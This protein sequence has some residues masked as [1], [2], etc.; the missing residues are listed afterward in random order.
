MLVVST[1]EF[2]LELPLEVSLAAELNERLRSAVSRV[3]R[4]EVAGRMCDAVLHI[5]L[6]LAEPDGRPPTAAQVK[7]ALDLA[8]KFGIDVPGY[9]L[10]DRAGMGAFLSVYSVMPRRTTSAKPRKKQRSKIDR[11]A[12]K[13]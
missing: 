11:Q 12:P 13:S 8:R 5:A 3:G 9:A 6:S 1:D 2:R 10:A 4:D 7:Y